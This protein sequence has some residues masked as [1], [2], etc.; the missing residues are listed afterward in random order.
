MYKFK[1]AEDYYFMLSNTV[2]QNYFIEN[3]PGS[4]RNKVPG[5]NQF[6]MEYEVG[7]VSANFN[8]DKKEIQEQDYFKNE[9]DRKLTAAKRTSTQVNIEKVE[10][11][12]DEFLNVIRFVTKYNLEMAKI[13]KDVRLVLGTDEKTLSIEN[14]IPD[15]TVR[16]PTI[17]AHAFGF[18]RSSIGP[19]I[20]EV[21]VRPFDEKFA[22][23]KLRRI[24]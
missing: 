4:F 20:T 7:L 18:A 15:R 14:K 23:K 8:L 21:A 11:D 10:S 6:P 22:K 2:D 5:F 3:S 13:G 17:W 9:T 19:G 24:F 16:I 1:P 12:D